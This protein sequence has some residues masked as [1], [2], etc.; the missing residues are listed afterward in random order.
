VP[1]ILVPA[2]ERYRQL[3]KEAVRAGRQEPRKPGEEEGSEA[4]AVQNPKSKLQNASRVSVVIPVHGGWEDL[5]ACLDSLVAC[6]DLLEEIQ[7]VDDASPDDAPEETQGRPC[8]RLLRNTEQR[9]FAATCNYGLK[10]TSGEIIGFLNSDTV[11]PRAGLIHLIEALRHS[12]SI[13]AAGP[14]SNFVGH[15]QQITPTYTTLDTLD[16]FAQDFADRPQEDVETDMLVGFCLAVRKSVLEEIGAF[17]TRFGLGTFEDNDL[18]YRIRRAGYRL[19]FATRSFVHHGGSKTLSRLPISVPALLEHNAALF[20]Q[21]WLA[22]LESGYASHLSGLAPERI[23]FDPGKHPDLR[24]RQVQELARRADVSLCMIVKNEERVLPDCLTSAR[25]FFREMIV[26]DTGS[27]DRTVE[28]ARECGAQV[29][30]F[31]WTE[32]FAE[33]RNQSL[34]HATGRWIAWLDADDTLPWESGEAILHSAL[35][36]PPDIV[37]FSRSAWPISCAST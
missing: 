23:V 10:E 24:L 31:P 9:G 20:R 25:P 1:E 32:S 33:A 2:W 13:A 27:T 29:F 26:V 7:V 16:L 21:K 8:V 30:D 28:I 4:E 3:E 5:R 12:G 22:D 36:A 19:I 15:S 34:S 14:Y 37:G 17:E 6:Q 18:C 11:V 35:S